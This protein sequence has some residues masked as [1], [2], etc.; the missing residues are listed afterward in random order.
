MACRESRFPRSVCVGGENPFVACRGVATPAT[1][2]TTRIDDHVIL[3]CVTV[4]GIEGNIMNVGL[5]ATFLT[6]VGC[7]IRF[8]RMSWRGVFFL[9]LNGFVV[10]GLLYGVQLAQEI[11]EAKLTDLRVSTDDVKDAWF[12]RM[13]V[14]LLVI[15]LGLIVLWLFPAAGKKS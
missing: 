14:D 13:V 15:Y 8:S 3:G 5:V 10:L 11:R 12:G 1:G 7:S 4:A 9:V 2:A 6:V